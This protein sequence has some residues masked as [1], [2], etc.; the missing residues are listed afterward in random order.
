VG[1]SLTVGPG[2]ILIGEDQA[3]EFFV[4][5]GTCNINTNTHTETFEHTTTT[6]T[7]TYLNATTLLVSAGSMPDA[8]PA[9]VAVPA[10]AVAATAVPADPGL[11]G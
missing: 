9:D 4:P 6:T 8:L 7:E 5:A 2:S 10:P 11:T 1:S 3:Q